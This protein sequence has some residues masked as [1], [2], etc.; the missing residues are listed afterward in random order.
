MSEKLNQLVVLPEEVTV[1]FLSVTK[2][3]MYDENNVQ[4]LFPTIR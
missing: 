2:D 4:I 1:D 3:T